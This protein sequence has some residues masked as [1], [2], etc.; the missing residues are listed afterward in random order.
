MMESKIV[1]EARM[2]LVTLITGPA[3]R[4]QLLH[5]LLENHGIPSVVDDENLHM[6]IPGADAR[7]RVPEDAVAEAR[8][9]LAERRATELEDEPPGRG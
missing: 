4:M 9:V 5:G 6:A 8:T 3:W 2:E 7:L 1:W